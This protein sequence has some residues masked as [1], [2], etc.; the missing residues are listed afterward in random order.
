MIIPHIFTLVNTPAL[1]SITQTLDVALKVDFSGLKMAL[2]AITHIIQHNYQVL[3]Y[4]GEER[5]HES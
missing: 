2:I 1:I 4:P 3:S 5:N